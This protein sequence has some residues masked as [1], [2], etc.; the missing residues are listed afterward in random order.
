MFVDLPPR[1]SAH[2]KTQTFVTFLHY[3]TVQL[4]H[5]H[6]FNALLDNSTCF[7]PFLVFLLFTIPSILFQKREEMSRKTLVYGSEN[8]S[9]MLW[10]NQSNWI[11]AFKPNVALV[12]VSCMHLH[13]VLISLK[14]HVK[15]D[16]EQAQI[17]LIDKQVQK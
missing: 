15:C 17:I 4:K 12:T 9:V 2:Y 16:S 10:N 5:L 7:T 3:M 11:N 6:S 1:I 8:P 14:N 13:F